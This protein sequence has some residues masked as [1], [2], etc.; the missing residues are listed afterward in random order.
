MTTLPN[1][2]FGPG[3]YLEYLIYLRD[4]QNC[5][6]PDQ[7][8]FIMDQLPDI[9]N[10]PELMPGIEK[11]YRLVFTHKYGDNAYNPFDPSEYDFVWGLTPFT[12]PE[13]FHNYKMSL[14]NNKTDYELRNDM[15]IAMGELPPY[16]DICQDP[17][18]RPAPSEVPILEQDPQLEMLRQR[19]E[20]IKT[21]Y[22]GLTQW[23]SELSYLHQCMSDNE[24]YYDPQP[25]E[26]WSLNI[27]AYIEECKSRYIASKGGLSEVSEGELMELE[28]SIYTRPEWTFVYN[29]RPGYSS[30]CEKY[31]IDINSPYMQR[32]M[33]MSNNNP[34]KTTET[35][36]AWLRTH[37]IQSYLVAN[38]NA[39]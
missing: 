23:L 26:T 22:L 3:G 17:E 14:Q 2:F 36:N 21:Q 25:Y 11:Y 28:M 6:S 7:F 35:V 38:Q 9:L 24:I 12:S 19:G 27:L 18:S 33:A 5:P 10:T 34:G 13:D 4:V 37:P 8:R 30:F 39:R 16:P 20:M 29:P 32:S 15:A 1:N 31:G